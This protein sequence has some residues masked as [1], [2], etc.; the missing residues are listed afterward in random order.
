MNG[1]Y[2]STSMHQPHS[3]VFFDKAD[4]CAWINVS[5]NVTWYHEVPFRIH[6]GVDVPGWRMLRILMNRYI[7]FAQKA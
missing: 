7:F 4:V 3:A 6:S 5:S 1:A 2:D